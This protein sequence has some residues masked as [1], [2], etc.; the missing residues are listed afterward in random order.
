MSRSELYDKIQAAIEE[1]NIAGDEEALVLITA[2]V[3]MK[4]DMVSAISA[5]I[6]GYFKTEGS[7]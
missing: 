6:I 3:V 1:N 7:P 4:T 2:A 5:Y